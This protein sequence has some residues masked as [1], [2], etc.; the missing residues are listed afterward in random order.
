MMKYRERESNSGGCRMFNYNDL[1]QAD[2]LRRLIHQD[3][4][5]FG[6]CV[7]HQIYFEATRNWLNCCLPWYQN[8]VSGAEGGERRQRVWN[9]AEC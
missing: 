3:P 4:S 8:S 1:P 5:L 7:S 2:D 6:Q 9:Q